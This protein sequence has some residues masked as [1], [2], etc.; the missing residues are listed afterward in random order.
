[1]DKKYENVTIE[2]LRELNKK[3]EK[4]VKFTLNTKKKKRYK[5]LKIG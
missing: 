1:M 3:Q 2:N 5:L 4:R